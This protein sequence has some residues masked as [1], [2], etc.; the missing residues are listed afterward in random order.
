MRI[1]LFFFNLIQ[2]L[3]S[4]PGPLFFFLQPVYLHVNRLHARK[5]VF[6][7]PQVEAVPIEGELSFPSKAFTIDLAKDKYEDIKSFTLHLDTK[8]ISASMRTRRDTLTTNKA[9]CM[10]LWDTSQS[11]LSVATQLLLCQLV[12]LQ[13]RNTIVEF[14]VL[15]SSTVLHIGTKLFSFLKSQFQSSWT[16]PSKPHWKLLR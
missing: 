9:T 4:A 8:I 7:E 2:L 5:T 10:E 13:G 11:I 6:F 12:Q 1:Y 16:P 15:T 14:K 3:W